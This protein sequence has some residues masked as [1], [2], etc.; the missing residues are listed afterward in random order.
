MKI[1]K[2]SFYSY[3]YCLPAGN[4]SRRFKLLFHVLS[5]LSSTSFSQST[6]FKEG[7]DF[8]VNTNLIVALW[9]A[10]CIST[11]IL[12]IKCLYL[13]TVAVHLILIFFHLRLLLR[14]LKDKQRNIFLKK[15]RPIMIFQC[16]L[17]LLVLV[18]NTNRTGQMFS[19]FDDQVNKWNRTGGELIHL[20]GPFSLYNMLAII[21]VTDHTI[22]GLKREPSSVQAIAVALTAGVVT[23]VTFY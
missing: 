13:V 9:L 11:I 5:L 15:C 19:Y 21:A 1:P 18:W 8:L 3:L 16:V 14:C 2:Y 4:L 6:L 22:L 10:T 23:C 20:L 7:K 12:F 17:Q